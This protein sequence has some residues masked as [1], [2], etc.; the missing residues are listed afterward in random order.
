[1][2]P[3]PGSQVQISLGYMTEPHLNITLQ[4]SLFMDMKYSFNN[5]YYIVSNDKMMSE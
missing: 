2:F 5:P 1:M 3:Q 4:G